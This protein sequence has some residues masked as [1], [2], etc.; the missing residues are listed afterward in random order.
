[1]YILSRLQLKRGLL[2]YRHY[3]KLHQMVKYGSSRA[4]VR[5]IRRQITLRVFVNLKKIGK[6]NCPKKHKNV[7]FRGKTSLRSYMPHTKV[8]KKMFRHNPHNI[9]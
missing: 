7:V 3:P 6:T 1:M 2:W 4:L 5:T 9:N 8:G